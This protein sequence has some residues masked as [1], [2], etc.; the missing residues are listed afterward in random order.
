[1]K[2]ILVLPLFAILLIATSVGDEWGSVPYLLK[3]IPAFILLVITVV[4]LFK[5]QKKTRE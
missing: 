1:M 5:N 2:N 3:I 4:V